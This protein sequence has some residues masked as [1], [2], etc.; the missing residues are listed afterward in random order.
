MI[1]QLEVTNHNPKHKSNDLLAEL[2]TETEDKV[3]YLNFI[4]GGKHFRLSLYDEIIA[5]DRVNDIG[6]EIEVL[7]YKDFGEETN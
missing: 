4:V 3:Y 5:F 6:E 7:Y 2:Y 1:G